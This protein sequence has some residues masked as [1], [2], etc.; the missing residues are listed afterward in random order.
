MTPKQEQFVVAI[1]LL[2]LQTG[3]EETFFRGYLLQQ[4]AARFRLRAADGLAELMAAQDLGGL[5]SERLEGELRKLLLRGAQP[6]RG[7]ELLR[8]AG[9][10]RQLPGL[11]A[12]AGDN[13]VL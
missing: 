1:I 8:A 13:I 9:L 5:P 11:A 12:D 4:M 10:D 2:L 7:L 3:A 6:S